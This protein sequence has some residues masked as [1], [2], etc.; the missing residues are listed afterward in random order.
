MVFPS[1]ALRNAYWSDLAAFIH[2][3]GRILQTFAINS[4]SNQ[5]CA[6]QERSGLDE[7][8]R[9]YLLCRLEFRHS[10][11][12]L[13]KESLPWEVTGGRERKTVSGVPT[14]AIYLRLCTKPL[15]IFTNAKNSTYPSKRISFWMDSLPPPSAH[16]LSSLSLE[17]VRVQLFKNEKVSLMS[18]SNKLIPLLA[19]KSGTRS[20]A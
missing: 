15:S 2:F 8:V 6:K 14:R 11:G 13:E 17:L 9:M 4:T 19:F 7:Q 3:L 20:P 12:P 16:L 10:S 1:C 5:I 18:F